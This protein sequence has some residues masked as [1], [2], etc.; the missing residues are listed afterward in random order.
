MTSAGTRLECIV[1]RIISTV[2]TLSASLL[3]VVGCAELGP[4]TSGGPES[5]E[6]G[7]LSTAEQPLTFYGQPLVETAR[8]KAS[9]ANS[10]KSKGDGLC[11]NFD[12]DDGDRLVDADG[13]GCTDECEPSAERDITCA[14]LGGTY[15]QVSS[16]WACSY[17]LG[18]PCN[19]GSVCE[20]GTM[21]GGPC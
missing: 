8:S 17:G 15:V 1:K 13:D 3:I 7:T 9:E 21:I 2:L 5:D 12:C 20:G 11:G 16:G 19:C 18:A 4:D 6:A 10:S 14:Q